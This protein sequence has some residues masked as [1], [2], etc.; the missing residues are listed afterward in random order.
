MCVYGISIFTLNSFVSIFMLPVNVSH[1]DL[2]RAVFLTPLAVNS[3]S[4]I[5]G[6]N[7]LSMF[8]LLMPK[9]RH[10]KVKHVCDINGMKLFLICSKTR[11]QPGCI[12]WNQWDI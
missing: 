9:I 6:I 3:M 2:V 10:D 1:L 11:H 7:S 8:E 5:I 12:V 4:C